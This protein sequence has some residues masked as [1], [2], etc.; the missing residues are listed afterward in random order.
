MSSRRRGIIQWI[1]QYLIPLIRKKESKKNRAHYLPVAEDPLLYSK[2][3]L[4]NFLRTRYV[5]CR[6]SPRR[7]LFDSPFSKF[8]KV[9][10]KTQE[11][12]DRLEREK[13]GSGHIISSDG[14]RR[15]IL[16]KGNEN[17]SESPE[18][19]DMS[20]LNDSDEEEENPKHSNEGKESPKPS[21]RLAKR[22]RIVDDE[23]DNS[24]EIEGGGFF[25]DHEVGT[26]ESEE[27]GGFIREHENPLEQVSV[28]EPME[29][30]EQW[31]CATCTLF[32]NILDSTCEMC[33]TSR[34]ASTQT[35]STHE[36]VNSTAAPQV[37]VSSQFP[38]ELSSAHILL[39][40]ENSS[41]AQSPSPSISSSD[42]EWEDND[43]DDNS[44]I[45][46]AL[47][48][49][50]TPQTTVAV[51]ATSLNESTITRAV[52]SASSM[53]DWAGR[54]VRRALQGSSL[55]PLTSIK[56]PVT[57][58]HS[59]LSFDQTIQPSHPPPLLETSTLSIDQLPDHEFLS[60]SRV[61]DVE[62]NDENGFDVDE[63][64]FERRALRDADVGSTSFVKDCDPYF[65]FSVTAWSTISKPS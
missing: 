10:L 63:L 28:R 59:L 22:R 58:K 48:I 18:E 26:N 17:E 54:A 62:M 53:G 12:S 11:E 14:N 43:Y 50:P 37:T 25:P 9:V 39:P 38:S 45:S 2:T 35:S 46:S 8:N 36:R 27:E 20:W 19:E 51:G 41:V 4:A 32:N 47:E 33:G 65:R 60:T 29:Q 3:Q 30:R 42:D 6:L 56:A 52:M 5:C 49:L 1:S 24:A 44:N 57:E 13:F 40:A 64:E 21:G 15:Y 31:I 16:R 7:S 23:S 34:T 61:A 55:A